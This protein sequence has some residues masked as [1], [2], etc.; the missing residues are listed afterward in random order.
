MGI[1]NAIKCYNWVFA[2][3]QIE[4][5][6]HSNIEVGILMYLQCSVHVCGMRLLLGAKEEAV[7]GFGKFFWQIR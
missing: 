7:L 5:V 1:K 3:F 2:A 4:L 6:L